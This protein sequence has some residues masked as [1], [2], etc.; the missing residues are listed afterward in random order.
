MKKGKKAGFP[1]FVSRFKPNGNSYTTKFTNSNIE[2][3][4]ID[5][6]PYIKIPKIGKIRFVM[7]KKYNMNIL[8]P[9]YTR[10]TS[11]SIKH[12]RDNYTVSVQME[13]VIDKIIP[14]ETVCKNRI[15]SI[16]M[17]IKDFGIYGNSDF[18]EKIE[19]PRFIKH[20]AKKLRRL[21]Q[22]LNRKQFNHT[23][24]CGSKNYRKAKL[25][26]AE[27][28]NKIK[29]QRKDFHHK[30]S[31]KLVN[32]CDVFICEDLN[33]KGMVK[34]HKLAKEISSCGWRQF[35]NF[36]KYKIE[37]KGGHFI[38][39]NQFFASSKLCNQCG[40]KN[41]ELTLK[42][43]QWECPVCHTIHDRDVNAKINL[44]NEGIRL[45][46]LSNVAIV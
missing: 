35:L 16:D 1:K 11:I 20:N 40:Y 12:Q 36:V 9:E 46:N 7:P 42:I 6:L 38:Q 5:G 23:K 22:S 24:H 31:R 21:Q 44:L 14:V 2:L 39:V 27:L 3:L 4:E 29:N 30:L 13:T 19:N 25:K 26:V 43:R 17:G 10:I 33:I 8:K 45:L 28:H 15:Y 18:T 34:N 41:A 32:E 37:K